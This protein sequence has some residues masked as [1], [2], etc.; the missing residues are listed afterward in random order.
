MAII[1]V[2]QRIELVFDGKLH[3]FN[4][5]HYTT[6]QELYTAMLKDGIEVKNERLTAHTIV[7]PAP[8]DECGRMCLLDSSIAT[9]ARE[10]T[11]MAIGILARDG[12]NELIITDAPPVEAQQDLASLIGTIASQLYAKTKYF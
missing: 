4:V 1:D 3:W 7:Y 6:P 12:L 11:H 2:P 10:A 5:W 9:Y 8:G